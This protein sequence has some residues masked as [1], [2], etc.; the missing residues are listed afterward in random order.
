MDG[1]ETKM[2]AAIVVVVVGVALALSACEPA[3]PEELTDAPPEV[4]Q[5][6]MMALSEQTG[7]ATEDMEIVGAEWREWPDACLGLGEP[8]EVCAQVITPG[9]QLVVRAEG[10]EYVVRT[11]EEGAEVRIES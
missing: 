6:A 7:I 8:D 2:I 11:D 5:A 4:E 3:V 10:E 9:W 1:R